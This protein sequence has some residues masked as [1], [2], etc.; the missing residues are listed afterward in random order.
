M[1]GSM[2]YHG[3]RY[4][5]KQQNCS[6]QVDMLESPKIR[7]LRIQALL[8]ITASM[9]VFLGVFGLFR[10]RCSSRTLALVAFGTYALS[11]AIIACTLGLI[12]R[13]SFSSMYFPVWAAYLVVVLGR[14][15]S[16][17]AHS[18]EDIEHNR[19]FALVAFTAYSLL[20]AII[21][22]VLGLIQS[23]L[24]CS[25]Y[26][27]L[28]LAYLA[29]VLGGADSYTAHSIEDIER[30][31]S[32]N[33]DSAAKCFVPSWLIASCVTPSVKILCTVFLF[34]ILFMKID[35]RA[36]ALM[37]ASN[38]LMQKNARLITDYMSTK[39][40]GSVSSDEDP[41]PMRGCE[42]L[43]RVPT[44]EK[45][46]TLCSTAICKHEAALWKDGN[47]PHYRQEIEMT[48]DVITVEKV[49]KC[50]R[51]LL[52]V[53]EGDADGRLK[54]LCLS[55]SLF[56]FICLRFSGYS[57]PREAHNKLWRLIQ[58]M[59]SEENDDDRVFRL[60]EMELA[61]LFDLFYT[62]YPVNLSPRRLV[63]KLILLASLVAA[64][65][66]LLYSA[67]FYRWEWSSNNE[68]LG[69]LVT[70]LLMMSMLVV[71]IAQ[72]GIMIFS[73][74][75]KATYI[76]KYV[77]SKRLQR[78]RCAGKL[79]EIMCGVRLLKPWGRQLRQYSLL[80]SYGYSPWKCTHNKLTATYLDLQRNGQE[81]IPPTNLS[82]QVTEVI[83]RSLRNNCTGNLKMGKESLR[84]NL[85]D[86]LSWACDLETTTHVIM[87]W[88]IA[89]TFC[90]HEAPL[91]DPQLSGEQ[92]DIVTKLSQYLAY[93]VAF[94]PR[95]L[96]DP[97]CRTEYIFDCAV[98]EARELF[99]GSSVS[100]GDRIQKP[101][102]ID[103]DQWKETIIGR[104]ARLGTQLVE[105]EEDVWKVLADF[106]AEMMLYVAPSNDAAAHAKYLTTGGEF[107]THV[108]VLVS[109]MGITRDPRDGE[110]HND[111]ERN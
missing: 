7:L 66:I 60:I 12:Q 50:E 44:E 20:P 96:P 103:S 81:Q 108:W 28:W 64:A 11:P 94:A 62:K 59:T 46:P 93:L 8:A 71:E 6:N 14:A 30:W 38:S 88:H 57:L 5:D 51:R 55:F 68:R 52:S 107:V 69:V 31:K 106:W 33:V 87:V 72:F 104:G 77:Q 36:R 54:D 83:A 67:I 99:Q 82:D 21:A 47:P 101:K 35:E 40:N 79:I 25:L 19:A 58:H 109:H 37:F 91:R 1:D 48:D 10:R 39:Q 34:V 74:W 92:R 86:E 17:I 41:T 18:I 78:N 110:Q 45:V 102:N 76:C 85:F 32:F 53:S 22:Y 56:K 42:Y 49:W 3:S 75:A 97:A 26:F 27:P 29:I 65:L 43:V 61:F 4:L 105:R 98:R 95:L 100:M 23:A 73:E 111:P 70:I 9:L 2:F 16:Y 63:F 13:A 90:G 89:T 15:D 84:L 80:Q 24:S